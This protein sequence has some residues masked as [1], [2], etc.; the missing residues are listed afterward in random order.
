[1]IKIKKIEVQGFWLLNDTVIDF[2]G[3]D[4]L[5]NLVG[6]NSDAF[7]SNGSGKST[8]P[9]LICQ[10]LYNKNLLNKPQKEILNKHTNKKFFCKMYLDI[11]KDNITEEVLIE[12]DYSRNFFEYYVNDIPSGYNNKVEKQ[13]QLEKLLG[14]SYNT[15]NKLFFLSPQRVSLFS[16]AEDNA[17]SNFIKELLS[18]EFITDINKRADLELKSLKLELETKLKEQDMLIKQSDFIKEQLNLVKVSSFDTAELGLK[19]EK[20]EEI[21]Y[22]KSK[23][24]KEFKSLNKEVKDTESKINNLTSSI[25]FLKQQQTQNDKVLN[26]NKCPT[27][28]QE[29]KNIDDLRNEFKGFQEQITDLATQRK[30]IKDNNLGRYSVLKGL[31]TELEKITKDEILLENDIKRLQELKAQGETSDKTTLRNKL[32]KDL[33]KVNEDIVTNEISLTEFRNKVYVYELIKAC[34]GAKG[35]VKERINLFIELFNGTL[36]RISSKALGREINIWVEKTT[37]DSFELIYKEQGLLQRY[38]DLSSGTQ[39]RVDILLC[40]ALN[41]SIKTL[42]GVEVNLLFLDEVLSNIDDSGKEEIGKLLRY[43]TKEF[44][45]KS[46]ITVHHGETIESDYTLNVTREDNQSIISWEE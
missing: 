14:L 19:V 44:P 12:R 46:I 27:C 31:K 17:Q 20:L 24:E 10:A 36:D 7:S 34:T 29:I 45:N 6:I 43:I 1:M 30:E 15:F 41:L 23:K 40:L 2:E 26:L 4:G 28:K 32:R 25:D 11:T 38:Q 5:I 3:K 33:A 13:N 21:Q 39:R 18:L 35:F 42:T 9:S 37:K 22:N 8:L 16:T